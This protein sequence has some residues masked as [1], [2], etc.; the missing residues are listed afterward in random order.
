[1]RKLK[2]KTDDITTLLNKEHRNNLAKQLKRVLHELQ[3]F[4]IV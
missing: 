4:G 3:S 2:N 1:M